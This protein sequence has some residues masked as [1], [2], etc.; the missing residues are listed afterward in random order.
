[1]QFSKEQNLAISHLNGPALVLA[2]PGS[3]KTTVLIHRVYYL[4]K[5]LNI[6][7]RKILSITFSKASAI[8]MERRFQE[9][10]PS[11]NIV[12]KFMTI[13]AFCY[14][15]IRT[16]ERKANQKYILI[17][18]EYIDKNKYSIVSAIYKNLTGNQ[19]TEE[20]LENFFS[21]VGFIKNMCIT[22]EEF[23]KN[24]RVDI[25]NFIDIYYNYEKYKL[26]K[27]LID[28]DDML[29]KAHSIL[30]TDNS[31]LD[32]Y[33]NKFDYIQ[34]DEGQDTSI[35]QFNIISLIATPKN[36]IFVVADDD[37]SIYGFRGAYPK[38]LL[39]FKKMYPNG[40][41]Y[42]LKENYRSSRNIV[43]A[44]YSFISNNLNR[45]KK[46]IFTSNPY[47]S[48]IKILKFST[49]LDQYG[50]L[51]KEIEKNKDESL[52]IL[53]R[54]NLSSLGL[55][56]CLSEKNYKFSMRDFKLKFF[57]HWL[58]KD[59]FC[60]LEFANDTKN[61][62][63]YS[64]IYYKKKGYI[65]KKMVFWA[66]TNNKNNDVFSNMLSYPGLSEFYKMKIR[67]L[68]LDFKKLSKLK[69]KNAIDYIVFNLDYHSYIKEN[70][71]R[72]GYTYE[73]LMQM[74]FYLKLIAND[75]NNTEQL[76]NKLISLERNI[77]E[78]SK[79]QSNITLS[80]IHGAK[81]LEFDKVIIIDLINGQFPSSSSLDILNDGNPI[82]FEEERRLFYVG[83]T[84]AKYELTLTSYN[85]LDSIAV[86]Q[87]QFIDELSKI[88]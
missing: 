75:T 33:K 17:E 1:M 77:K 5:R 83:I 48:P 22:P 30:K 24:K 20:K 55:I 46:D 73:T 41:I 69:P 45:Y 16:Y 67:E 43:E 64:Q 23:V 14:E 61:F 60:F 9:T 76:R 84:R 29:T 52:A 44:S 86:K 70:C 80:T 88:K 3:G 11:A 53:Y 2:V 72:L 51:I 62:L 59:I 50:F 31:I 35:I 13:H 87:S 81:G 63:K 56:Y 25:E 42:Y 47:S 4:T 39:E 21:Y 6:N 58:I 49:I 8:D 74:I 32:L 68:E 54:N 65:S 79:V 82:E 19:I 12:P 15:I 7:P 37:Q 28:F 66:S 85:I 78:S 38:Q 71:N 27:K 10:F 57:N 34:I 26:D 18:N 40:H 36:N